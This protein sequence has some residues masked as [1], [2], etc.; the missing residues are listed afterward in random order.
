MGNYL[1]VTGR[2]HLPEEM[3]RTLMLCLEAQQAH[4]QGLREILR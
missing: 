2:H 4:L 3:A 1:L